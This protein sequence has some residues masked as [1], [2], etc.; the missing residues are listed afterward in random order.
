MEKTE[1]YIRHWFKAYIAFWRTFYGLVRY[2]H[3][4]VPITQP[5]EE[6]PPLYQNSCFRM[7]GNLVWSVNSKCIG[8]LP[9]FLYHK[10]SSL[11]RSNA[12]W[13]NMPVDKAFSKSAN[14]NFGRSTT[15][16]KGKSVSG[17]TFYSSKNKM[18]SLPW[19]KL[20]NVINLPPDSWLIILGNGAILGFIVGLCYWLLRNSSWT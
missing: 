17:I 8:P 18:L 13:N 2:R 20:S 9:Q 7:M 3:L 11:I 4:V 16:R 6:L 1:L 5:S 14:D 10:L 12:V 19:W 15:Y